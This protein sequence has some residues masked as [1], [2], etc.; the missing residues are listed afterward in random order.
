MQ[1]VCVY[2]KKGNSVKTI[3]NMEFWKQKEDFILNTVTGDVSELSKMLCKMQPDICILVIEDIREEWFQELQKMQSEYTGMRLIVVG[4]DGTYEIVRRMFLSGV[5]DYLL[6]PL[7]QEQ[8]G[9]TLLRVYENKDY[10]YVVNQLQDRIEALV[11]HIFQGGGEENC[12]IENI[13]EQ[14]Y[15]DFSDPVDFQQVADKAKRRIYNII[16]DRKSWLRK[17]LYE[18]DYDYNV[19]FSLKNREAIAEEW[20]K[21]FGNV[22]KIVKKYQMIDNKLVY[23]IGKYVVE[24]VDEKLSLEKVSE[25]VFLNSSYISSIFKKTTGMNFTDFVAE[26]KV[27]RAKILLRDSSV[28][29]YDVAATVGYSNVEY[30]TKTFKRKTGMAPVE[31]QKQIGKLS[32]TG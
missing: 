25:G 7:S 16:I 1:K 23:R 22:S 8:L 4:N 32:K 5:F 13:L 14:I 10:H 30:F 15:E 3:E 6:D 2:D 11:D 9:Q 12:I 28:K 19:G 31:Y 18:K 26:V 27:D 24:H 17:F 29:I 21:C 20:L